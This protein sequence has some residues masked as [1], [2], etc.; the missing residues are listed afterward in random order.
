[1]SRGKSAKSLELI[2]ASLEILRDVQPATVRA[3]C[4]WLFTLGS[5]AQLALFCARCGEP[6]RVG[7]DLCGICEWELDDLQAYAQITREL[8]EDAD[9]EQD[10]RPVDGEGSF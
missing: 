4:Y 5:A 3:V 2:E 10:D 1:M 8:A 9:R 6:A 7:A